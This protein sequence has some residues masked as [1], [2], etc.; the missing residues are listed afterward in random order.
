MKTNN[1]KTVRIPLYEE[2]A[3]KVAGLVDEGTFKPG[4]K[5]PSIRELSRQFQ[6]SVNTVKMAYGFLEDRRV[7]EAKPQSGYYVCAKLPDVPNE[8]DISEPDFNPSEISSGELVHRIMSDVVNSEQIQFGAAIPAPE[9]I[10]TDKL[11]RMLYSEV[12]R[13]RNESTGYSMPPGN[14]RLRTQIA[15]RM[16]KAGCTLSPDDIVITTGAS[17]A[18]FLALRSICSPGDT[19]A[20][21]SPIYFNF[22]EM[23][24]ELGLKVL[25]IPSSPKTGMSIDALRFALEK[26]KV[27]ACMVI[28][29]FNN[30]L[31]CSMPD[32]NKEEL[33]KLLESYEIPLIEDDINGDLSFKDERPSVAKAWDKT[34]N[35]LLCSSFS[36]TIAPGY[37]IGWIAPGKYKKKVIRQKLVT[38]IATASPPQLA[39]AEFLVSGGYEHHLRSLRKIYA[40]NV[41]QMSEAVGSCFP[42]GTRV[43]RPSGGFT[44][45]VELPENID[46]LILYGRALKEGI[47]IAP[48]V[49]FSATG[50]FKNCIRLNAGFWSETNRW[51]IEALG[52]IANELNASGG[53]AGSPDFKNPDK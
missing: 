20:I 4:D 15:K 29:N 6:V 32:E 25:E 49:I 14:K 52:R 33:V 26:N 45:W 41:A 28:S 9:L 17:E 23:I 46:G 27:H 53:P 35:V 42:G 31:G 7:I 21:G 18:V 36:K 5:V 34:G 44:L 12:R 47:A 13:F 11:N 40:K 51:A 2:M 22:V 50:K 1:T 16:M 24:K 10:P 8:P 39:I 43:T 48:G 19:L 3:V 30:P 38:N 37:R